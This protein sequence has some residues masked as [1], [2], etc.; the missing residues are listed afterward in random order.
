MFSPIIQ[1]IDIQINYYPQTSKA[2]KNCSLVAYQAEMIFAK[3]APVSLATRN[4]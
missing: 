2:F 3:Y 1:S 4:V